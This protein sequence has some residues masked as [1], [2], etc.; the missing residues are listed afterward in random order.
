MTNQE[1]ISKINKE[2]KE[3]ENETPSLVSGIA[4]I[5]L[6]PAQKA[7]ELLVPQSVIETVSKALEGLL[8]SLLFTSDYT[9]SDLDVISTV[10]ERNPSLNS[11]DRIYCSND[12]ESMDSAADYYWNQNLVAAI[13][14]G[15]ITG[16]AG[17]LGLV[18]NLPALYTVVFRCIQQIAL[19]YGFD[20]SKD[21][22][23]VF[24]LGILTIA[25]SSDIETKQS[26]LIFLKQIQ[27][28]LA[29]KTW[30]KLAEEGGRASIGSIIRQAAK[31][32]GINL[33][34]RKALMLVPAIGAV[35]GASFDGM[36]LQ[37]IA[38]TAKN[39]YR[40]KKLESLNVSDIGNTIT[41]DILNILF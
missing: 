17:L 8:N 30:K 15:G 3:W 35:I 13:A 29:K 21:E 9:F 10:E 28:D 5:A 20:T 18:A 37:D 6:L 22:E 40:K 32:I 14:Q 38:R 39:C 34:K 11:L 2:I 7:A 4:D 31:N 12:I 41:S 36:Y 25:S 27:T 16:A 33:T 26:A 19:C 23:K 24:M 1:Y